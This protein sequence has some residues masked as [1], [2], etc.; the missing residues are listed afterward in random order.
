MLCG[1]ALFGGSPLS[2]PSPVSSPVLLLHPQSVSTIHP[3]QVPGIAPFTYTYQPYPAALSLS[4]AHPAFTQPLYMMSAP[5]PQPQPP[6]AGSHP[7]AAPPHS[8]PANNHPVHTL[9]L[10]PQPLPPSGPIIIA[11][12]PSP[13]LSMPPQPQPAQL[14]SLPPPYFPSPP[15]PGPSLSPAI[16]H[17]PSIISDPTDWKAHNEA[18]MVMHRNGLL[19]QAVDHLTLAVHNAPPD[20]TQP[21]R[22][23]AMVKVDI[24]T[25]YKLSGNVETA[26]RLYEEALS[27]LP[28]F[29]PAYFNLAV[30]YSER[31]QYEQALKYYQLAVQHNPNYVEALCVAE[32]VTVRARR[33]GVGEWED[34]RAGDVCEDDQLMD[35]RGEATSI[36]P[37]IVPLHNQPLYRIDCYPHLALSAP[38]VS[39]SLSPFHSYTVSQRH[40]VTVQCLATPFLHHH[41][42]LTHL[43]YYRVKDG[44]IAAETLV[45]A[46]GE[47]GLERLWERWERLDR[48]D[49]CV[50]G[51]V[52]D[53][54]VE[55]L[56]RHLDNL[57]SSHFRE[58]IAGVQVRLPSVTDDES[59]TAT[60]SVSPPAVFTINSSS[61][62]S[63]PAFL[64]SSGGKQSRSRIINVPLDL[65]IT[66]LPNTGTVIAL[67]VTSP[68]NRYLLSSHVATHNCNIGVIYK[69]SAQLSMA[70]EY[71][72][73]ALK[74]NPNFHIAA[75]NLAIALTDKGTSVKNEGRIEEGI[76]YYKRAL[77]HNSKYPSS[78]YNLGVAYA[79]KGRAD[80]AKV[81]LT[82]DHRVLTRRG[83]KGIAEVRVGDEVLSFNI[84]TYVQEWKAVI[85][86]TDLPVSG[87]ANADDT[88]YRMQGSSMDVVATREHRM[89]L[90]RLSKATDDRLQVR[91]PI[92]YETVA[93]L[94]PT[95][96]PKPLSY[97][98]NRNSR[99]TRFAHTSARA[100]ICA[101]INRQ[102][103]VKIVI[104]G[105]ERVC[106]WWWRSD[107][108]RLF[109]HFLGF[110]LGDGWLDVTNGIVC[111]SQKKE[112]NKWLAEELL[113][114]VFPRWW[115]RFRIS[116]DRA[117]FVYHIRC[118]PL[119]E[120]LR[121]MAIGPLG[122]NPRDPAELRSY[123]HFAV[124][125]GLA[126]EEQRSGYY[127][128]HNSIDHAS[129]W[130][131]DA[132]LAAF[133]ADETDIA[134][135]WWCGSTEWE[136][137]DEM[138]L[139]EDCGCG[140]HLRCSDLTAVPEGEWRCPDC[141]DP[142]VWPADHQPTNWYCRCSGC[143]SLLPTAPEA[144]AAQSV[145]ENED[146]VAA[147]EVDEDER[148]DGDA[149]EDEHNAP[150][151]ET[152]QPS[153]LVKAPVEV[154]METV[155]TIDEADAPVT[156][157]AVDEE[158]RTVQIP[159]V[160]AVEDESM[161]EAL[162][163][164]LR[165]A[166]KVVWWNNGEWLII[167][168]HWYYLKRWLGDEQQI[169]NVYS[170]L[171][172]VQ[173]IA[174]LDG[175]CRA[176]DRWKSVQYDK[177]GEPT[178]SWECWNSS[179][180]L[181]DH[182][183][184]VAQLAGARVS[185]SLA[186][187]AG[188]S[189]SAPDGRTITVSVDHWRLSFNFNSATGTP[190]PIAPLAKPV[191]VSS[192]RNARGY[193][194][195]K[196][197]KR[198]YCITVDSEGDT[199]ANFLTQRLSL[200]RI[201]TPAVNRTGQLRT[202]VSLGVRAHSVFVG[203]CYEMA[204]LFDNKC[205]EAYNNL[206]VIYK[207]RGNLDQA[208]HY[209]HEALQ[210]N[211]AFS[212][213]LNNLSVIYTMLGKLDEAYE[214]W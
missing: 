49:V 123:P 121:L 181:I 75:S 126:A 174:L 12:L 173:A 38:D 210:A 29:A 194:Q 98:C 46:A 159:A 183:Q 212:Q 79:E 44:H 27:V 15:L 134:Q 120:Y 14:T 191:N 171:S 193:Y 154:E 205:A 4:S 179:F 175:F 180:P 73:K 119:Y 85:D 40:L 176:D 108:Q 24:G 142:V 43:I 165:A 67:T 187:K 30:I 23:L 5:P 51:E 94:L 155:E 197:D 132:M 145:V 81:C 152:L 25:R 16:P 37:P 70:I 116:V 135:C 54:Y 158:G 211:P 200:K 104:P 47:S 74:A 167:N 130:T 95:A 129:T 17:M 96:R 131:E 22:N 140:M 177:T 144:A 18:G 32:D 157:T 35:E 8:H 189:H 103:A 39:T 202:D 61:T 124:H 146:E 208:I 9:P 136:E 87:K 91:N 160:E 64:T 201:G 97:S 92:G 20:C 42:N 58:H 122:Y 78:W 13:S 106:D 26:M 82:G 100:L 99:V 59:E 90:A 185:L 190:F 80:D 203:N 148:D 3:F 128:P 6:L 147:A 109:L 195:Y 153:V 188:K 112:T 168:G 86:T 89:L 178:G 7:A 198:V 213:T 133:I 150:L 45:G 83:W 66:P 169:A 141:G 84:T 33:G 115:F 156:T 105:L 28:S 63:H 36:Q 139:C 214:Y 102:P 65:V 2:V 163:R 117:M 114:S 172:R 138:V 206:G 149:A 110:W 72:E 151:S 88:L 10:Q 31:A 207:D 162:G 1:R 60:A 143:L 204:V 161:D 50:S 101:G 93:R 170:Q 56:W 41:T 127:M 125:A 118:P 48:R 192:N 186:V 52:Y 62:P 55:D 76:S 111:V 69:N 209:Y 199:N 34:V 196:D 21:R 184:L 57:A 107:E 53:V 68:T 77:H 71:Y 137:G 113:P 164:A 19:E 166:G 182:L 11:A